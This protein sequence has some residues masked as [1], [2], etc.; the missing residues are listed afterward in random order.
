MT[1]Q[2][3]TNGGYINIR[4]EQSGNADEVAIMLELEH[5]VIYLT[6]AEARYVADQI[7]RRL[8]ALGC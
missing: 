7:T 2:Q 3:M 6:P 4:A 8:D 1:G 5:D